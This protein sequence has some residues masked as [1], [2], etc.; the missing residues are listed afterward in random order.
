MKKIFLLFS[1]IIITSIIFAQND[2]NSINKID[3]IGSFKGIKLCQ[4]YS[5][6]KNELL[7]QGFI[8]I[9]NGDDP[10]IKY[11]TGRFLN[12][13]CEILVVLTPKTQIVW[14]IV[15][16]MPEQYSWFSLK[17]EYTTIKNDLI[18]KYGEPEKEYSFFSSP[19]YEGDG[20]ELSASK[21]DKCTYDA[22]W[23]NG[24]FIG[25]SF[26]QV[27]ICYESLKGGIILD[28]ENAENAK[29]DL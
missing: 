19:Y 4:S 26:A 8:F 27:K 10:Q 7:K 20:Y 23:N 6:F 13:K 21:N 1:M 2:V 24:V 16:R 15:V 9:K 5:L 28:K 14:K 12:E 17:D 11:F 3:S 29:N 18:K 22:F 25:I